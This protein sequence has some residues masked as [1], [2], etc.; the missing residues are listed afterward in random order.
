MVRDTAERV[1][2]MKILMSALACE[3]GKGSELEVGFRAL[4]AAASRHEVWLLT[5]SATVSI[6]QRAIAEY[7]WADRVHFEGIYFEV[8]D[9]LYPQLT[10][11]GFHL[12]YDR[13]QRRA[14]ARAA[15]LDRR[16]DFD[17]VHHVTLA[18]NWTRAGVTA[19]D[20]PLVWGPVGG[21]VETPL[22]LLGELGW[23]GLLDEIARFS[24]RRVLGRIGPARLTRRR[25]AV[26]FAQN[27][28]TARIMGTADDVHILSNATSV[29]MRGMEPVG[30]RRTDIVLAARLLP[31]KGGRLA[32]RALQYV[33]HPD[34]VLRIFGD[35]PDRQAIVRAANRWG[36]A[37]RLRMEGR[38]P[39]NELLQLV[40]T[41]GVFLH[42]AFH[43]EAGLAVAEALSL[44]TPVVCLDRGGPPELLQHWP[45]APAVAVPPESA[46]RTARA[47]AAAIDRFLLDPPPLARTPR[48]A[49]TCFEQ[50]LLTAYDV[51]FAARSEVQH[52]TEMWAFPAGK[53][54]V[55]A[56]TPQALSK[57]VMVY[58]F[59]RRLP[60]WAHVGLAMQIRVPAV[61]LLIAERRL[62]PTPACGWTVWRAIQAQL[63]R[64]NGHRPLK[65][66]HFHSQWGKKRF[67]VL[68][69]NGDGTPHVFVVVEPENTD[70]LHSLLRST[71][72]FR[73]TTCLDVFS[74]ESWSVRQYEPLPPLHQP[75]R[76]NPARIR[77]VAEDASVAL[78]SVLRRTEG[79]PPHWRPMHGDYVPWNL[80]ED[81]RGQL[82][83]L[84]WEDAGWAPPLS[85][86]VRYAVAYH[87][88]GWI[89][90]AR[91]AN[92]V[93]RTLAAR[94]CDALIEVA[95]FWLSHPNLQIGDDLRGL[96]RGKAKDSA[97]AAREVAVF[98][99]LA[100]N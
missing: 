13:W 41:A 88:L 96:T 68:G 21:G 75:A 98:R 55:F 43:D 85:D 51:A 61:R 27:H 34:A 99:A 37:H 30:A 59:G 93:R 36:V 60:R 26:I 86:F 48:R 57:G 12:Y 76:W 95:T 54:Q 9:E 16:I 1:G 49:S 90:P 40:S 5:N 74:H 14:A 73:V 92:I 32:V 19:V 10:A 8:D 45:G 87:S 39:R 53:P 94:P 63:E 71:G 42:P 38:V 80:R 67:N 31:W 79:T 25:A 22:S 28:D 24:T 4:I 91:I 33:R 29:D 44:G 7:P 18:A 100:S 35:G 15:E 89:S 2:V 58:G 66:I 82:W 84:D 46:E 81:S 6:V 56:D 64:R 17:V 70:N 69:L 83:L 20:K 23:R 77:R 72:S 62:L 65:W 47:I 78:E 97:R 11:P 3:P 52:R 50:E